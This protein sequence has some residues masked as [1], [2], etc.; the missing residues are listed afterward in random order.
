MSL[1]GL[2]G[3]ACLQAILNDESPA[4]RLLR[5]TVVRIPWKA[6]WDSPVKNGKTLPDAIPEKISARRTQRG[7][8]RRPP[9]GE[10]A[11]LAHSVG[12]RD[13]GGGGTPA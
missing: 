7:E 1:T 10:Q 13:A 9:R 5:K 12:A 3:G 2:D 11:G 4:S 8:A 6:D